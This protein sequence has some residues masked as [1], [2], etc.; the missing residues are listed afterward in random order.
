MRSLVLASSCKPTTGSDPREELVRSLK[1][2]NVEGFL[3]ATEEDEE[4]VISTLTNPIVRDLIGI[5]SG[6]SG[7]VLRYAS[8]KDKKANTATTYKTEIVRTNTELTLR[9][10]NV[11]TG[12]AVIELRHPAPKPATSGASCGPPVFNS[13]KDCVNDFNCKEG[14]NLLCVANRTCQPQFADID[15]CLSNGQIVS[16]FLMIRPTSF[17]CQLRALVPDLPGIFTQ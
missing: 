1:G 8:V 12:E 9:A 14:A 13:T 6:A 16:I 2:A 3:F 17:I 5:S 15:C 4:Q 11:V 7:V 10:T